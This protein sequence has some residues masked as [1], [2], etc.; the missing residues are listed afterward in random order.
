MHFLRPSVTIPNQAR[1]QEKLVILVNYF[2]N[3]M[4]FIFFI[5]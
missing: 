4:C 2:L 1:L 3:E 5:F